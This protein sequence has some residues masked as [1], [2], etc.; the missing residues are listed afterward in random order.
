MTFAYF[1]SFVGL[2]PCRIVAVGDWH[3]ASSLA[4][5]QY[6]ATRGAYKRG[7]FETHPLRHIVPRKAVFVR[8]RN[9]SATQTAIVSVPTNTKSDRSNQQ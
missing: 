9:R 5:V 8:R 2:V 6:T 3:D 4:R 1:D 7:Q